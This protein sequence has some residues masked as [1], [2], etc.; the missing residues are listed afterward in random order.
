MHWPPLINKHA[1]K[2]TCLLCV[3]LALFGLGVVLPSYTVFSSVGNVWTDAVVGAFTQVSLGAQT[4]SIYQTIASL[5]QK[6]G[7][8]PIFLGVVLAGFSIGFPMS[9]YLSLLA[10]LLF[11]REWRLTNLLL[12]WGYFSMVEV[13][14]VSVLVATL[15]PFLAIRPEWGLVPF[16]CSVVTAKFC[17]KSVLCFV[18]SR[19]RGVCHE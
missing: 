10:M 6:R 8:L 19:T 4:K 16:F 5:L 9:K 17:Q 3:S 2:A 18:H 14:V 12:H 13:Y 15:I 7:I 11:R 1:L